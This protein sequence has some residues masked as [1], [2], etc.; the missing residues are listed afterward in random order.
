[1]LLC[2]STANA[3]ANLVPNS[4]FE[5]GPN[6][7]AAG[8]DTRGDCHLDDFDAHIDDWRVAVEDPDTPCW[9]ANW[10]T[11]DWIDVTQVASGGDQDM[12]A[13]AAGVT[14]PN[15]S[16]RFVML[17][18][19]S[20][21]VESVRVGLISAPAT[22]TSYVL[23]LRMCARDTAYGA[24]LRLHLTHW[25][26]HWATTSSDNP[27]MLDFADFAIPAY[28]AHQWFTFQCVFTVP[29]DKD[30]VLGNLVLQPD[31]ASGPGDMYVDD[32]RLE[33]CVGA[34]TSQP[35]SV[36]AIA[37]GNASLSVN[38][39]GPPTPSYQWRKIS[40]AP[41]DWNDGRHPG[42]T[43][44]TLTILNATPDDAGEYDVVVDGPCDE[45][46]STAAFLTVCPSHV[47]IS[48]QPPVR[49][50][51]HAGAT[52]TLKAEVTGPEPLYF[53]WYSATHHLGLVDGPTLTGTATA[54]LT[55][56]AV[57]LSDAGSYFVEVGSDCEAVQSRNV[58]LSVICSATDT[59]VT[60]GPNS[61]WPVGVLP[62]TMTPGDVNGDGKLDLVTANMSS[63]SISVLVGDGAGSFAGRADF[64]AG[65]QPSAIALGDL[66]GDGKPDAVVANASSDSVSVL[67]GNGAGG[68]GERIAF[69]AGG[70]PRG[71]AIGDL[72][73]DGKLDL[74]VAC[75]TSD[76]M[77]ILLGDGSGGFDQRTEFS[78]GATPLAIAV[79]DLNGDGT[80]DVVT[81]NSGAGTVSLF[82]GNG[83][84]GFASRTDHATGAHPTAIAVADLDED[85]NPDLV[86][87]N[88]DSATVSVL[89]ADGAGGFATRTDFATG[90]IGGSLAIADLN[91]DGH[92]DVAL[93]GR[94]TAAVSLLLGN[95]NGSLRAPTPITMATACSALCLGDLDD[96]GAS[97]LVVTDSV[98]DA[99]QVRLN[100]ID[101]SHVAAASST[102]PTRLAVSAS[103]NPALGRT[104][105]EF[106]LPTPGPAAV[107]VY[108]LGGRRLRR[109]EWTSL[110]EGEHRILWDGLGDDG[111]AVS[112]GVLFYTLRVGDVVLKR[113]LVLMK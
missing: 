78:C 6:P 85:G 67:A 35:L 92:A 72:N 4:G 13:A 73:G 70:G 93:A 100:S 27:R 50:S 82:M 37:G 48:K 110:A 5:T 76:S 113:K 32:A 87:A 91:G 97:D 83:T 57:A 62:A 26:E 21:F 49:V 61:F 25:A 74:A 33:P 68:F 88:G 34:I 3:D 20:R 47:A 98:Q 101:C 58:L 59:P 39:S 94:G 80:P 108:D 31:Q 71:V 54:S 24:V 10:G 36:D 75:S 7:P 45:Q 30:G 96:D 15:T 103:P 64:A 106:V 77:A 86:V 42:A 28:A 40:G 107:E 79:A 55:F 105:L 2:G 38:Y 81:V 11:P 22:G 44:R 43:S 56:P 46:V 51:A 18:K 102:Q 16:N 14:P 41:V 63:N 111:R 89:L 104:R 19:G 9:L 53:H 17:G 1:M 95:G 12:C 112:P 66:D 52:V 23:T 84:G 65:A 109:W 90:V 8:C 99:V 29:A 69:P 60:F